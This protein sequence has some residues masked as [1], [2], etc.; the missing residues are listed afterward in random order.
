MHLAARSGVASSIQGTTA[1]V[2][3][4]MRFALLIIVASGLAAGSMACDAPR[5][6][7]SDVPTMA[8]RDAT[9]GPPAP[10]V[11]LDGNRLPPGSGLDHV[12]ASDIARVEVLKGPAATQL[13]GADGRNGVI[14][15]FTKS[16]GSQPRPS[17]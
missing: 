2:E 9:V 16:A 10:L 3:V 7:T 14:L 8:L 12:R 11:F 1:T 5:L 17:R 13:Y 15:V 4:P 6:T